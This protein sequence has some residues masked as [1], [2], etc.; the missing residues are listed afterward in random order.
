MVQGMQCGSKAFDVITLYVLS[1]ATLFYVGYAA[2]AS[3]S[4]GMQ[5]EEGVSLEQQPLS[6]VLD[7]K[8]ALL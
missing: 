3:L 2:G 8:R 5:G 7:N 4:R 1:L 6:L